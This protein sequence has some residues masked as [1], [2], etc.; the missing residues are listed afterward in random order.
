MDDYHAKS[1]SITDDHA[2]SLNFK[3]TKN[4]SGRAFTAFV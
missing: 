2:V 1:Q 4:G 3:T